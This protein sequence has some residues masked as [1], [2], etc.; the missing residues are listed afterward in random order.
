MRI[1]FVAAASASFW[2]LR[3]QPLRAQTT[4]QSQTTQSSQSTQQPQTTS[5]PGS[6]LPPSQQDMRATVEQLMK[7]RMGKLPQQQKP[8]P[9]QLPKSLQPQEPNDVNAPTPP[10]KAE[11]VKEEPPSRIEQIFS[12]ELDLEVSDVSLDLK[13][14][15]YDVFHA[16][17]T[18]FAPVT[19]VPV[20]PD[21][22]VGPGD[23]FTL[24]LWG[25]VDAQYPILVDRNGQ[26]VLPEVGALKV[27]GMKF[28]ELEGYLQHELSRKFSDF[29]MCIT[30]DKL[31]SIQ[32]F[33]VGDAVSPG[34][35]TVSSLSTV[36]NALVA[37]GGPSK[38]G[39]LRKV[40]LL[41]TG[42][43]PVDIDLYDFL[44]GGDKTRD[45]RLQ[46]GDTIFIPV[47]GS[48]VAVAGNV[49]RP[50]IYEMN[51]ST[52]LR[53]ALDL[54]GGIGFTGWLQR[55]QVE[56]IENHERRIVVDFDMSRG[57]AGQ[58]Q[59]SA[60]DTV[61]RDGD[62]VKVFAVASRE[63]KVV[64]LDGHVIRPG[65]YQWRPGMRLRDVL[66]SYD[67]LELQPN[68][69]H[70]EIERLVPPDL[71]PRT[72]PFH[73]GKLLDGDDSEN[74]ELAQYDTVRVFRWDERKTQTVSISGMVFDPNQYQLVPGMR[75]RD[76]IDAAG[77]LQK[78]A[79]LKMAEI[80]RRHINQD[81][82][83][84]EMVSINLAKALAG[85]PDNNILLQDYDHLVVRPIPELDFN[86]MA[87]IQGE[88]RFPGT[89][90]IQKGEKLSSLIE[91]AGGYTDEAYLKGAI[92][93]RES[94]QKV[95]RERL[96]EL[97]KKIEESMLTSTQQ[98]AG[99]A[100]DAE[101]VKGQ[102]VALQAK[103][104][105]LD[106]LREA[107]VTGRVV[108]KLA[109]VM[110]LRQ[111]KSDIELE[112]NDV[113]VV[114][115]TPGVVYVIGEVFNAT[116]LL[117]EKGRP[118]SYYLRRVGGMTKEADKKQLSVVKA[119]GSVVSIEQGNRARLVFWDSEHKS[120]FFGG[121]MNT[122]MEP[123]D[124]IVVPRKLDRF[125]WLKTTKDLTQIVF[126]IAVA[127]GIAF[128]I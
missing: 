70:G 59:A 45:V 104:E 37:A 17:V 64:H 121:F 61:L 3:A 30:M 89:Y 117:Y 95:Q 24:T 25:R 52:T 101:T 15:G 31:R 109:P 57:D 36:I 71:H 49:K 128:A 127:A 53:Q 13:Q 66:T 39:S 112:P 6:Q 116:S 69:D 29:K 113:L 74:I 67:I 51:Q 114:P 35:Y 92:F 48:V 5:S 118:L 8:Q 65:K 115:Q 12:G 83:T 56:R 123:G 38:N 4:Q 103:R 78:N 14:F 81:G 75:V 55:V 41:R 107:E 20:G 96:D 100:I 33:T 110:E 85:D 58:D 76:L 1:I 19:N 91:R 120:W 73:L 86:R 23:G 40:R 44:Q 90:P 21:Y 7:S 82:M 18:T 11:E 32:V 93:T 88:V 98:A 72:I 111:S 99:G 9:G 122:E 60:A 124:T 84:T 43:A 22:I 46:D 10:E 50:A 97:V 42:Q 79:Y 68:L 54:A 16:P 27:W 28:G 62:V 47:I 119:D 106:K 126:Q 26:I 105:L 108:V 77:G 80:T 102:E 87:E 2:L 125:F 94:A 34:S 63:E